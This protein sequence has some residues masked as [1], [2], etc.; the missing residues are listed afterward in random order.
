MA[1]SII[2]QGIPFACN[3]EKQGIDKNDP[4]VIQALNDMANAQYQ[5]LVSVYF[6]TETNKIDADPFLG[7]PIAECEKMIISIEGHDCRLYIEPPLH[8]SDITPDII[9]LATAVWQRPIDIIKDENGE[10]CYG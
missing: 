1:Y 8:K 2:V 7:Y 9:K 4:E 10:I 3:P 5:E 6:N